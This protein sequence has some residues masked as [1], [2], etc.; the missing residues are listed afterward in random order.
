MSDMRPNP[1]MGQAPAAKPNAISQNMSAYNPSD[2]GQMAQ[3]GA[4]N[5]DMTTGDFITKVLRVPLTAPL[6]QFLGALKTQLGNRNMAGKARSMSGQGPQGPSPA[7]PPAPQR[8]MQPAPT[9]G[10]MAELS[11]RTGG[12]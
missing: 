9:G 10:G 7:A 5:K 3:T 4:I 6:P 2:L 12:I 8:P 1:A 11:K